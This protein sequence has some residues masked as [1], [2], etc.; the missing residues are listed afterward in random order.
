[1][2]LAVL[3]PSIL[4]L[5]A[6]GAAQARYSEACFSKDEV[7]TMLRK[8]DVVSKAASDCLKNYWKTHED[9]FRKNNYSKYFGVRNH[10][11]DSPDRRAKALLLVLAPGLIP[12]AEMKAF[13]DAYWPNAK[14]DPDGTKAYPGLSDL[15]KY[16]ARVNPRL[17]QSIE[18]KKASLQL[19]QRAREERGKQRGGADLRGNT[20]PLEQNISCVDLSRRCLQE[21]FKAAGMVATFEKIDHVVLKHDV[22][23]TELQKGLSDLGWKTLYFNPDPSQD[24]AWDTEDKCI[25]PLPEPKPGE[26]PHV[27]VG[28][29]GGH[30]EGYRY[31]M[32]KDLYPLG[33]E[34]PIPIDDKRLLVGFR[35]SVPDVFKNV[36]YFIGTAHGGYHVF[37]GYFGSVIEGHSVRAIG[38]ENNLEVS[39]FNPIDQAYNGK[40]ECAAPDTTSDDHHGGPRWTDSEHYRSGVIVVP[41]GY[42]DAAV[43]LRNPPVDE[44]GCV[45]LKPRKR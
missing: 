29:W 44:E 22:S 34:V 43:Q 15:E 2:K 36:P 42:L 10:S 38:S 31:V 32:K 8:R 13:E 25:A 1:M 6:A 7:R 11:L 35:T 20:S 41:P 9:F 30:A 14:N 26:K 4:A 27:W 28:S 23:G 12:D 21:G 18:Q 37:P 19:V 3:A 5:L 17:Y 39:V 45:D 24:D 33:S 40:P 16:F